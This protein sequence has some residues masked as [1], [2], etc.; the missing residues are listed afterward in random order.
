MPSTTTASLLFDD[1]DSIDVLRPGATRM[2][3]IAGLTGGATG[4]PALVWRGSELLIGRTQPGHEAVQLL[5]IDR[6]VSR[7]IALPGVRRDQPWVLGP[8]D[9]LTTAGAALPVL[10]LRSSTVF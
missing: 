10:D 9:R 1:V 4:R 2:V 8:D 3:R 6:L 7:G 5:D